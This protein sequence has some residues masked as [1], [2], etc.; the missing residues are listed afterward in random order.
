MS[1]RYQWEIVSQKMALQL[2]KNNCALIISL[3]L[4]NRICTDI[5]LKIYL[6]NLE[7]LPYF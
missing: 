6:F 7:K 2:E 3:K 5:F 4:D 1:D